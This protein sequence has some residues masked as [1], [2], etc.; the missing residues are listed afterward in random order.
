MKIYRAGFPW[1][2]LTTVSETEI[3]IPVTNWVSGLQAQKVRPTF[4]IAGIMADVVVR[5][6]YQYANVENDPSSGTAFDA[7]TYNSNGMKYVD[8]FDISATTVNKRMVR[9][10]FFIKKAT[11][12]GTS[13]A[14][15][16]IGGVFEYGS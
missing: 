3:F 5:P 9:F 6:G 14:T 1:T 13:L 4:E 16:R 15:I 10:G 7:T 2:T 11:S 12:S 8:A